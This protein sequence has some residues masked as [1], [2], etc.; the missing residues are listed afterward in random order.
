MSASPLGVFVVVAAAELAL[1]AREECMGRETF[2]SLQ[3]FV[4][5]APRFRFAT[6]LADL[7]VSG[8][9]I[10]YE[11]RARLRPRQPAFE[12]SILV[13]A[14]LGLHRSGKP[15]VLQI[16]SGTHYVEL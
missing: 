1:L 15:V 10:V 7:P 6:P 16:P 2:R 4:P 9:V 14:R 3:S 8:R 11:P 13:P 5:V 12:V